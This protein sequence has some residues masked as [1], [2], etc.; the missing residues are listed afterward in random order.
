VSILHAAQV[1]CLSFLSPLNRGRVPVLQ[2]KANS[3]TTGA[4]KERGIQPTEFPVIIGVQLNSGSAGAGSLVE[5]Q[6]SATADGWTSAFVSPL[7]KTFSL[8]TLTVPRIG[9][10]EIILPLGQKDWTL[11][12]FGRIEV[13][14]DIEA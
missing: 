6:R 5:Q 7:R 4:F 1:K 3:V 9:S 14:T 12:A 2:K 10:N 11:V 13:G 8:R